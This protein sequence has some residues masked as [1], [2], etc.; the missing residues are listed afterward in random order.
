M[1][2]LSRPENEKILLLNCFYCNKILTKIKKIMTN[3]FILVI[4][5]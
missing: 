1:I 5:R 4:K 2:N 3:T